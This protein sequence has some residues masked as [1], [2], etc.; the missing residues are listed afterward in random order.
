MRHR[1][2]LTPET[3]V[4]GSFNNS[5]APVLTVESGDILEFQTAN[6]GGDRVTPDTTFEEFFALMS[7]LPPYA[8]GHTL[9]GPVAIAGARPG[10][11]LKVDIL[12]LEPRTHGYNFQMPGHLG[13]GLLPE[14]FPDGRIRHYV[15]DLE[16]GTVELCPG[17]VVPLSPFLGILAVAPAADGHHHSVP[18]GPHG[19]NMD[20]PA[21]T[22]GATAYLPIAVEGALFY[23]GDAHSVQ[24]HGEVGLSAIETAM[25]AASVR[26]TLLDHPSLSRPRIETPDSWITIGLDEDLLIASKEAIRDMIALL[27]EE[28]GLAP[29]DAYTT[30]S[31]AADLAISQIVN[32]TRGVQATISKSLFTGAR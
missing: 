27:G 11:V 21:L 1:L 7:G 14:D 31:A 20:I 29:A 32:N 2:D 12:T 5:H 15:H 6:I 16:A 25:R 28:Y 8:G 17:V 10:Q 30:C 23:A 4:V 18:P 26:L 13:R 3:T 22:V 24:G 9:T 19:G